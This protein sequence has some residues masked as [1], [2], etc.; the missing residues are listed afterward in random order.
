M[1]QETGYINLTAFVVVGF[2]SFLLAPYGVKLAHE[3]PTAIVRKIFAFVVIA[4]GILM[5]FF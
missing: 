1:G 3:L 2:F 5:L 4:T